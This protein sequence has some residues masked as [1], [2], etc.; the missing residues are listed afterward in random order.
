MDS[1]ALSSVVVKAAPSEYAPVVTILIWAA[2]LRR[3]VVSTA[4]WFSLT[5][6]FTLSGSIFFPYGLLS[7]QVVVEPLEGAGQVLLAH[8]GVAAA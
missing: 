1:F 2:P 4:R 8:L 5:N 7:T 3:K 6:L